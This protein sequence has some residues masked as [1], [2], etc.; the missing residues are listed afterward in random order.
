MRVVSAQAARLQQCGEKHTRGMSEAC[1]GV[2]KIASMETIQV[3]FRIRTAI[4]SNHRYQ[5]GGGGKPYRQPLAQ[6]DSQRHKT[7]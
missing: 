7:P 2:M 1:H 3:Q 4:R 6:R 5:H